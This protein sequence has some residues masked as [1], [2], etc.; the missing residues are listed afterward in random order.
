MCPPLCFLVICVWNGDP[1]SNDGE[2]FVNADVRVCGSVFIPFL[3]SLLF[4]VKNQLVCD[5]P[6]KMQRTNQNGTERTQGKEIGLSREKTVRDQKVTGK[7]NQNSTHSYTIKGS[8]VRLC[9]KRVPS[10]F[11][12]DFP[13]FWIPDKE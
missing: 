7:Q 3:P 1:K 9:M 13:S 5:N 4:S 6:S 10:M 11:H 12:F 8:L 2:Q